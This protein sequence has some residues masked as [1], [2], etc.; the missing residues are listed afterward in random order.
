MT[1]VDQQLDLRIAGSPV[2]VDLDEIRRQPSWASVL[3]LCFNKSG[4]LD[5]TV[6]ADIGVDNAT[7]SRVKSG[8]NALS[9]EQIDNLM[10]RCGNEAPLFWLLL[11][12]GYDPRSLRRIETDIER[13]NRLL[14][15]RLAAVE[16]EREIEKR[17]VRELLGRTA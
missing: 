16:A 12:R 4:L 15:E 5:K 9:G 1:Y 7:W 3:S 10:A 14:R 11:R 13:E 8:Q 17:T 2:D 6:A